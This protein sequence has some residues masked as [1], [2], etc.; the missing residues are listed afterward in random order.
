M[1]DFI[2]GTLVESNLTKAVI[3]VNG[4]GYKLFIPI[5]TF[6]EM[7]NIGNDICLYVSFVVREDAQILFGFLRKEERDLFEMIT[8]VS[9]IGPKTGIS[10]IGHLEYQNLI[11][12][13][14]HADIKLISK[15]PGIGKKTAERLVIEMRDKL[16]LFDTKVV[17]SFGKD[18]NQPD[19]RADAIHALMN[20]G[21]SAMKAQK[22]ITK[23]MENLESE[24]IDA[25]ELITLA[26]KQI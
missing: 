23:A 13:I 25:G 15:V 11:T 2:K 18:N 22:A 9:G 24:K 10:L 20:L 3:D 1:Y 21:Y 26:L 14:S 17:S 7:P 5:S 6:Q 8:T 12:A 4:I 19:A 16:K